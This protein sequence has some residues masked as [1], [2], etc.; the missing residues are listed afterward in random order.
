MRVLVGQI[1][2]VFGIQG[3]VIIEPTGDDPRRFAPGTELYLDPRGNERVRIASRRGQGGRIVVSFEGR[4]DRTAVEELA[5]RSLYQESA[6]LPV[7]PEGEYYE[8]QLEGL[9]VTHPDG[10]ELGRLTSVIP[11]PACDLYEVRGSGGEWLIPAR[12]EFIAWVD[13]EKG[14]LRLTDRSDLLEAQRQDRRFESPS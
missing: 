6:A 3:E 11:A 4:P 10:R 5:R 12:K 14:E 1:V 7:L 9:R 2:N 8:F 13:L